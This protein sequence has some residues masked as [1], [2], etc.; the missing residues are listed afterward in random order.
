MFFCV[1]ESSHKCERYTLD[2]VIYFQRNMSKRY[3]FFDLEGMSPE[4]YEG[5]L[6][7]FDIGEDQEINSYVENDSDTRMYQLILL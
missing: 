5:L 2:D 1:K 6:G 3:S 7:P 4:E